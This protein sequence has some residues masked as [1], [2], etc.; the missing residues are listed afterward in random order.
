[1]DNKPLT[2][3][4]PKGRLLKQVQRFFSEKGIEID[5]TDDRKLVIGDKDN[6]LRIFL[7]KNSDLP[8][9]ISHGIAGLGICGEDVLG[10]SSANLL[11]LA[12][13]PFGSTRMCLA[14]KKEAN[15][16]DIY[17]RRLSIATKFPHFTRNYYHKMGISVEIIKLN[18]SVELAPVLGLTPYIVDLVE[19]GSTLKANNLKVLKELA[20]INVYL[21]ANPAYYKI[22]YD[23]VEKLLSKLDIKE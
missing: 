1:M 11:K 4:L 17:S 9:Y 5:T 3:A 20:K 6:S 23:R 19:T 8:T 18:G 14:G 16:N 2:M 21:V 12:A 22:N 13:M 15:E 7:V 10:E